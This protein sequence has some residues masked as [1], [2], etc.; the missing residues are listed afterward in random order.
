MSALLHHLAAPAAAP[1][2]RL[3]ALPDTRGLALSTERSQVFSMK[4]LVAHTSQSESGTQ[5]LASQVFYSLQVME[6]KFPL[7][8]S[9]FLL[10]WLHREFFLM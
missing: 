4:P 2:Q 10:S 3:E 9:H 6:G 1:S 7:V 8:C 5:R